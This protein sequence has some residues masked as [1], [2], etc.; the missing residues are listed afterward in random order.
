MSNMAELQTEEATLMDGNL[1]DKCCAK[2][3]P[4]SCCNF[5]SLLLSIVGAVFFFLNFVMLG[6]IDDIKDCKFTLGLYTVGMLF[7]CIF[8]IA[9][10]VTRCVGRHE[11]FD[12]HPLCRTLRYLYIY[13]CSKGCSCAD[14]CQGMT[15][16]REGD[17][18]DKLVLLFVW[19]NDLIPGWLIAWAATYLIHVNAHTGP[20]KFL[21]YK[22]DHPAVFW[23]LIIGRPALSALQII[24][25]GSKFY[26]K[27]GCDK[28]FQCIVTLGVIYLGALG[29]VYGL[30][31]NHQLDCNCPE[32]FNKT[33][34]NYGE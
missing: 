6:D 21:G 11:V 3:C 28:W 31:I 29:L 18:E 30:S 2:C 26:Q 24:L 34:C 20:T 7:V 19:L 13:C 8:L 16:Y 27:S 15:E 4:D 1:D 5:L 25:S 14:G 9:A 10:V 33:R 22:I 17:L 32:F 12:A 23:L